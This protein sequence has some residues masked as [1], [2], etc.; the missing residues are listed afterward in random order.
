MKL[1]QGLRMILTIFFL[2]IFFGLL[3]FI[4]RA[5]ED[6]TEN[7]FR[8]RGGVT[9]SK[10]PQAKTLTRGDCNVDKASVHGT[11][12]LHTELNSAC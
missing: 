5:A 2:D 6:V 7:K 4:D 11:P 9:N 1:N 3:A 10:E 8:E 12:V